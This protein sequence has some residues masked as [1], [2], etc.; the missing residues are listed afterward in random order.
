MPRRNG[1]ACSRRSV[2]A[3]ASSLGAR[4]PDRGTEGAIAR[5]QPR[6][7]QDPRGGQT[8][9]AEV[10]RVGLEGDDPPAR[11]DRQAGEDGENAD[12]RTDIQDRVSRREDPQNHVGYVGF[13]EDAGVEPTEYRC[14]VREGRVSNGAQVRAVA[15]LAMAAPVSVDWCGYWPRGKVA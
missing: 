8:V 3:P 10:A 13:V 9:Q 12:I 2:I 6:V 5:R 7:R 14:L 1:R 4:L 11:S 15:G